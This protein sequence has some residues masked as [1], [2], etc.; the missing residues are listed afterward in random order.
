MLKG[1]SYFVNEKFLTHAEKLLGQFQLF[2]S[3]KVSLLKKI[4]ITNLKNVIIRIG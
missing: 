3:S 4:K 1:S 2:I